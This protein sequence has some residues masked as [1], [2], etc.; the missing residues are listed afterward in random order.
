MKRRPSRSGEYSSPPCLLPELQSEAQPDAPGVADPPAGARWDE[1]KAWRRRSRETLIAW[2]VGLDAAV[3]RGLSERVQQRLRDSIDL[4]RFRTIGIYWPIR[5]EINLRGLARD[6]LARGGQ[7]GLPV[8]VHRG[9]PVEFWQ[10][11]PGIDMSRGLWNI[12]IPRERR[13]VHPDL[14]LVPLVGFDRQVFRLGYGGGYYDRTLAA[15]APRPFCIGVGFQASILPTIC[16]QPHDIPM[17]QIVTDA[18]VLSRA[19]LH[20][21]AGH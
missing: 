20:P 18:A 15:A 14:L 16:P 19:D 13:I 21:P 7:V 4:Q 11:E 3:R 6:H 2:R 1:I 5:G 10:W 9:A 17:D 12:P 8:V